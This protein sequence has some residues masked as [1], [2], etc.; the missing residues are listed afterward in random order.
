MSTLTHD[1]LARSADLMRR[2]L[3]LGDGEAVPADP[4]TLDELDALPLPGILLAPHW[5]FDI[6]IVWVARSNAPIPPAFIL[7]AMGE[8]IAARPAVLLLASDG[9]TRYRAKATV[10]GM[11]ST[12]KVA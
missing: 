11:L 12:G 4:R 10:S 5:P 1:L 8:E 7:A 6:A 3:Y 2:G 9:E